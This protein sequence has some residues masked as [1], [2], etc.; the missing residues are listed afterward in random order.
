MH[1]RVEIGRRDLIQAP[2]REAAIMRFFNKIKHCR[3]VAT[4]RD[5][6][7]VHSARIDTPMTA[8]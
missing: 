2:K 1:L 3:C 5:K 7:A 4:R 6:L 8:R